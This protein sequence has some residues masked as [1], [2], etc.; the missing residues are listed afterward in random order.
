MNDDD[1]R[2]LLEHAATS[3]DQL[4]DSHEREMHPEFGEC[5]VSGQMRAIGKSIRQSLAGGDGPAQVATEGYRT[6]WERTFGG[7][8][9]VVGQA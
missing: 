7:K 8:R 1:K 3:A 2:R 5:H 4:A 6:S 9:A